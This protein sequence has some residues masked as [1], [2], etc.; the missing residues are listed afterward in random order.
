MSMVK[1]MLGLSFLVWL[2]LVVLMPKQ[3]LYYK[4]EETLFV[5]DIIFNEEVIDEKLFGLT[6]KNVA[7]YVK[8]IHLASIE[9]VK[10]FTLLF[11]TS[12]EVSGLSIDNSLRAMVPQGADKIILKHSLV[13]PLSIQVEGQG[14]FG[15][16]VGEIDLSGRRV[17]LDFNESKELEM[18]K[19]SLK[20]SEKGWVYETSF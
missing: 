17:H 8:G 13:S 2:A 9:E 6:L 4:L 3:E 15:L 18:L 20:K 16:M 12:I 1:Y 19:P 7:V 11:Y 5:Q 14:S 10:L